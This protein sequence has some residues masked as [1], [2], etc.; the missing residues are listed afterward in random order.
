V[1]AAKKTAPH[2]DQ[3]PGRGGDHGAPVGQAKKAPLHGKRLDG[4]AGN[5]EGYKLLE[6]A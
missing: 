2:A 1:K 3:P 4:F 6:R 5:E